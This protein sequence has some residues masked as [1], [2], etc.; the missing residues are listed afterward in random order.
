[1]FL[2]I[3]IVFIAELIIASTV[4]FF[5][6]K[7]DN[8]VIRYNSKVCEFK[9]K[10]EKAL[11]DLKFCVKTKNDRT[12]SHFLGDVKIF[13]ILVE[14]AGFEPASQKTSSSALHV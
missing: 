4:I 7:A 6:K 5:V 12:C 9:P 1:M 2:L 3:A 14:M 10:V 13:K 11:A 8:C